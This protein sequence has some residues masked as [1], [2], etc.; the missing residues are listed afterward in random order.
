[1][2]KPRAL[3]PD[4]VVA[5]M[6]ICGAPKMVGHRLLVSASDSV[7]EPL[8][9]FPYNLQKLLTDE[10]GN[11]QQAVP[12]G[13]YSGKLQITVMRVL[14]KVQRLGAF[15]CFRAV[16]EAFA[17]HVDT[18]PPIAIYSRLRSG[19]VHLGWDVC[20]GN[21]WASASTEGDFPLNGLTGQ[22][23]PGGELQFNEWSL[24]G[25]LDNARY[26]CELNDQ[27]IPSDAPWYPVA[28][29]VDEQSF[30]GLEALRPS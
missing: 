5:S 8:A 15:A 21:G 12:G 10:V 29:C 22:I 23:D 28:V 20:V 2:T 30:V 11:L 1:M 18:C 4:V 16:H 14:G 13:L 25:S 6:M 19:L 17:S 26:Y 7:W 27:C 9:E 24:L 3:P